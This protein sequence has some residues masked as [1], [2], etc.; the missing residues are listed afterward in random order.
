MDVREAVIGG[1]LP[2][3]VGFAL[4]ALG[5]VV[6]PRFRGLA[7]SWRPLDDTG[8]R[9]LW[10]AAALFGFGLV[11]ST[12]AWQGWTTLWPVNA[13]YRIPVMA[14]VLAGTGLLVSVTP[15]GNRPWRVG[16]AFVPA[17][18]LIAWGLIGALP[19]TPNRTAWLVLVPLIVG[20]QAWASE[21]LARE[22]PR[23]GATAIALASATLALPA[24]ALGGF[25]AG[26]LFIGSLVAVL[27]AALMVAVVTPRFTLERGGLATGTLGMASVLVLANWLSDDWLWWRVG[28]L[29]AAPIA[30]GLTARA[31][32]R[33][34]G[35]ARFLAA[36]AIGLGLSGAAAGIGIASWVN[37]SGT[38]PSEYG[39]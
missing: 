11:A 38:T 16:L 10:M 34:S 28:L 6:L 2:G 33:A 14:M 27:T 20:V 39:Y 15:L 5:W 12:Y 8:P 9:P 24:V 22:L 37:S 31:L 19:A 36:A 23:L 26:A 17:G 32:H 4:L 13:T 7:W 30:A 1:F 25:A 29:A 35:V 3:F 21:L 18:F